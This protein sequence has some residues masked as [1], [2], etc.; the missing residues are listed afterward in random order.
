MMKTIFALIFTLAVTSVTAFAPAARLQAQRFQP[1][2]LLPDQAG[3]LEAA[4]CEI[5]AHED[6]EHLMDDTKRDDN[7]SSLSASS[8]SKPTVKNLWSKSFANLVSN[9]GN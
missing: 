4:A 8:S 2:N 6:P 1:L 7:T 5:F 9:R 3:E